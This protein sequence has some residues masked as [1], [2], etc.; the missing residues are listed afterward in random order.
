MKILGRELYIRGGGTRV[1]FFDKDD[2]VKI[3]SGKDSN[4][5]APQDH[6][7]GSK[8]VDLGV[9][10][11]LLV[12][13]AKQPRQSYRQSFPLSWEQIVSGVLEYIMLPANLLM[14]GWLT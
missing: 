1:H 8:I 3:W 13:R 10:R 14:E 2:L 7:P 4:T 5:N 11:R 6:H 9:D 12:N